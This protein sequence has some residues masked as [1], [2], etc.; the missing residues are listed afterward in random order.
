[1]PVVVVTERY[2]SKG[3]SFAAQRKVYL[4]RKTHHKKWVDIAKEVKDLS[5]HRPSPRLVADYYRRFSVKHGRVRS[6]Y[7]KC[8]RKNYKVN[9]ALEKYL[10]KRLRQL[11]TKC[12]CTSTTLQMDVAKTHKV[13]L[14]TSWICK[15]LKKHG[16]K[17][18]PKKAKRKYD[19]KTKA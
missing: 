16:Y 3:L 4:L 10:V 17:W 14:S 5:G 8:G 18:V 19:A 7:H 11:R 6:K 1:M 2:D 9:E 13:K 15:I 12:V